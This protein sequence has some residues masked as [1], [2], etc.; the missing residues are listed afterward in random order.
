VAVRSEAL[1][2]TWKEGR[3]LSWV[4]TVDHKR[5][6][7]LYLVTAFGFFLAAGVMALLMR[8]QL[9]QAD[10][11]FLTRDSYNELFTIHGTAM[12]FLFVVP[13]LAGFGNFL[14]PLMLGARDMA[15]PRL[16]AAT[17]WLFLLGG[18]VLLGSFFAAGGAARSGWTAYTPL[19]SEGFSP[20]H[21]QDLWILGIHLTSLASL[22]GAINFIVTIHNMRAPGMTWMR[23][24][25]FVWAIEAYAV[26]LVLALPTV[27]AAATLLLLDRQAG[28]EFFAPENGG[29]LLW[30][31]MFWFFG[32]PEVYIMVLPAMG[33]VSEVIPVFSR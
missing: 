5:I 21:G 30:Q 7:V 11:H 22:A 16:N 2:P 1:T 23:I 13:M 25:L 17:Y 9:S 27:S 10:N 32:H 19:S 24:P 14:V 28:Q 33:I 6:G 12:V 26:L 31:H 4:T 3:V 29:S 15:F 8:A 20:G 18:L